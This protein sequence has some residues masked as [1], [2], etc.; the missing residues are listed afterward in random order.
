LFVVHATVPVGVALTDA[1]SVTVAVHVL[2]WS[3][4]RVAGVQLTA[5]VVEAA[6]TL[7]EALVA[8]V[9]PALAAVSV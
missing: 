3:T 8:P 1:V 4:T 2:A 9:N 7:K 5:V 6:V